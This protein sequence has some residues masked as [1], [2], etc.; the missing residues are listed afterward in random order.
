MTIAQRLGKKEVEI[1]YDK[2]LIIFMK[3]YNITKME[4]DTGEYYKS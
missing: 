2:V 4:T 1:Y 3:Y